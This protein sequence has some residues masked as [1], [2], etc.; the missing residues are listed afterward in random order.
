MATFRISSPARGGRSLGGKIAGSLF[1]LPFLAMGL[2]FFV[3][4]VYGLYRGARTYTWDPADCLIL[5]SSVDENPQAAEASE[6]YRFKVLYTYSVGGARFTSDRYQPGYNGSSEI[7]DAQ[8]LADR[9]PRGSRAACYV[10]PAKPS[11]AILRRP[12][13]WVAFFLFLPLLFIAAGG[14]GIYLLWQPSDDPMGPRLQKAIQNA[15][16]K[17]CI[18]AF[19]GLFLLA[20]AGVSLFFLLPAVQ[21]LKAKSWQATPCTVLTSQLQSHPGDDS[22]TYSVD[23]SYVYSFGGRAYRSSRY[24]FLGGSSGGYA[25]KERIVRRLPPLTRTTCYVNPEKPSEAVMNRDFSSEYAFGLVPLLF[26][27][28]GLGGIIFTLR[29]KLQT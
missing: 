23:V 11:A 15:N 4:M 19:F 16:P 18:A 9:Y 25:E 8:Q 29:G 7:E 10:D 12:S 1:L 13:L 21:V 20:G 3:L 5:E 17:G 2:V 22:T 6:A 27:A 28:V 26:V 24:Q 14:G